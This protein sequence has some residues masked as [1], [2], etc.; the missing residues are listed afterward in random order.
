[1]DKAVIVLKATLG[2]D[3][4]VTLPHGTKLE[5]AKIWLRQINTT[6]PDMT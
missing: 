3:T 4:K 2:M 6:P 5:D 1:M